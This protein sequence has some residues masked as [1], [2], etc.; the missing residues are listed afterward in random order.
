[1]IN[2]GMRRDE[3]HGRLG[4]VY[5]FFLFVLLSRQVEIECFLCPY[6]DWLTF[7]LFFF[8]FSLLLSFCVLL[9]SPLLFFPRGT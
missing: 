8:F 3:G 4:G 5:G 1:M 9:A 2:V 7:F 6:I